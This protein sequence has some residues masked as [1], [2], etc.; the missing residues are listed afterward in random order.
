[1]ASLN[2][3]RTRTPAEDLHSSQGTNHHAQRKRRKK[4]Q[5]WRV[6]TWNVRS[7]VDT[8]GSLAIAS[9]RQDGQRGEDRKV[10]LVVREMKRYNVKVAGLQETKWFGCDVYDVAG[11]M[12]L[13]SGRPLP[14]TED[15]FQRGEG[16]AL[17]LLDWAVE[18]WKNGGRQWKAWSSRIVTASVQVEKSRLHFVSCYAPTRSARREDKDAFYEDLSA[19]LTGIPDSDMYVVLG[20]LNARIGSRESAQDQWGGA[21]GPHGC[22]V[23]NDAGR[24]LLSFLTTHQATA[25]NTWFR[26]KNIHLATWQHPKSKAWSC[27][28]YILMR[29]KD[30]KC[31]LDVAVK[32][33]AECNTD[34][35]FLCAKLRMAWKC[36]RTKSRKEV[37]RFDVSGLS[38][39]CVNE[40]EGALVSQKDE[41]VEA[42]LER[43][44]GEWPDEGTV[45]EKWKVLRGAL[46]D[47]AT[48]TL[49]KARRRQ[50]DWFKEAEDDITPHLQARNAAYSRWIASHDRQDLVHFRV[51]R[52]RA[53]QAIR[54]AKNE[55][56]RRKAEEAEKKRFGGKEVWQCIRDLQRGHWGRMPMKV[57]TVEGEDGRPC[58]T[59]AEQEE[60]WRGHFSRVLNVQSEFDAA[61]LEK[62]RQRLCDDSLSSTPNALEVAKALGKLKNG[63]APGSSNILPE[64]V[65]AGKGNS[66]FVEILLDVMRTAWQEGAVPKEWADAIIVPIPKKGNLRSCD[67]WRGIALLEVVG[68]VVARVIQGRLQRVA[69]RELPDSQ[70]GFRKGRGCSDMTFVVRQLAEKATEHRT[71]QFLVFVDLR[72]AYD[73][74]PRDALWM[75]MKKLGVPESLIKIVRSFHEGMEA[76]VRVGEELL[77]EIEVKNGLRQGCTMAPTLFNLYSCVV[78][79]R[80]LE[81][82]RNV[83]GVG[84]CLFYKLDQQLFRRSTKRANR[85]WLSE[86]QFADDIALLAT[87]RAAAEE[88]CREY[89]AT[90]RA[91]G[92]T[93]SIPKTKF[94]VVGYGVSEAD[95]QP[96]SVDG[97]EIEHVSEFQYLGSV[98]AENGRIDAEVD[99]RIAN[100]SKAFGALRRAV[101]DDKVLSTTT[102]RMI[103]QACV[104]SVLLY[105]GECWIPLRRHLKRLDSFHHRCIRTVLGISNRQ[106]WE[107]RISSEVVRERWGDKEIITAMLQKRR[108]EWLGHLARMPDHR[109]PKIT[110]FGWMP[111]PRPCCGPKRRWRDVLKKDMKDVRIEAEEWYE[112]A[113][114][115]REWYRVYSEGAREQL[116]Q[117]R[118][119]DP[120]VKTVECDVCGRLFR[121]EADKARH[122][123]RDERAKPV[124]EQRGSVKCGVCGRWFRSKGGLAVHRCS[125][126]NQEGESADDAQTST[127][128][129][130][131]DQAVECSVCDRKF[132]QPGDLKRHKCRGEREKPIQEQRGAVQCGK[133]GRWLKSRGGLAVHKCRPVPNSST[134]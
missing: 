32:R 98:I 24:E 43:A 127:R 85:K 124:D 48:E 57:V 132:R 88:A 13:T 110:L 56:F 62:V 2:A 34:N 73:S 42:V 6:G 125:T 126:S 49:G 9:R 11:C 37:R 72:K 79:E 23:S 78:V 19:V 66:E 111:Q 39:T 97:G 35:Q 67:N 4:S 46:V 10:D 70:C 105:G 12:V 68:K 14:D 65:K 123:C 89:Q 38:H 18:A 22:G 75:A 101:F 92:L 60:R 53:R 115:R 84:T 27:I 112:L 58:V 108:L 26:K 128:R 54:K 69:E 44:G 47:V 113:Q 64:M 119:K 77:E 120:G 104:L 33:G 109:M 95:L 30:K 41:Y 96:I 5:M 40:G 116:E 134:E 90:A 71:Q 121:R 7:M 74:V 133:C 8:E 59:T 50:P 63:K 106:Q 82:V 122:K 102:K 130:G 36:P 80:W 1:M 131:G 52:G 91:F 76:R 61:E 81:K 17:V 114:D 117:H 99:R 93:V 118:K 103:Y 3:Y 29:Q 51:I 129:Q 107:Q 21:R 94:M 16:V 28:D 20:D 83:E 31:C 86:C 100:A 25:C 87:T 55:W 45:E 15:S